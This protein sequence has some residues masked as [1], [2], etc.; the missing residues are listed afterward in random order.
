[1]KKVASVRDVNGNFEGKGYESVPTKTPNRSEF[2]A[3]V[4]KSKHK[5][6]IM[7]ASANAKADGSTVDDAATEK[8]NTESPSK[9]RKI[10]RSF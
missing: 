10:I 6:I 7:Q 5:S 3:Q 1:M 9:H 2:A 8:A 4:S